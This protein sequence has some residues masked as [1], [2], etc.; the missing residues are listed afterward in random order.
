MNDA[1]TWP[2]S[3]ASHLVSWDFS[4]SPFMSRPPVTQAHSIWAQTVISWWSSWVWFRNEKG[5]NMWTTYTD[6]ILA[7]FTVEYQPDINKVVWKKMVKFL[8]T[9]LWMTDDLPDMVNG[10]FIVIVCIRYPHWICVLMTTKRK[11]ISQVD[12]FVT[13]HRSSPPHD[14]NNKHNWRFV[15]S[16]TD[17][18]VK[19]VDFSR[20]V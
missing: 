9:I 5:W 20:F 15:I 13:C 17:V 8:N 3:V 1:I 4:A 6:R 7:A 2:A 14:N 12:T 18:R 19:L 10:H 11:L 16:E